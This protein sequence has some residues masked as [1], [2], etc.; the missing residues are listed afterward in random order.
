MR[1]Q[2]NMQLL[3]LR[4]QK[5]A[6]WQHK[7]WCKLRCGTHEGLGR[8]PEGPEFSGWSSYQMWWWGKWGKEFLAETSDCLRKHGISKFDQLSKCRVGVK[9]EAGGAGRGYII[10]DDFKRMGPRS[11]ASAWI[12]SGLQILL[13]HPRPIKK[14]KLNR[15]TGPRNLCLIS[16]PGYHFDAW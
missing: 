2:T 13:P 7:A 9:D 6:Q 15:N 1:K 12:L 8:H 10:K 4:C 11:T 14:E 3:C 16:A 5:R